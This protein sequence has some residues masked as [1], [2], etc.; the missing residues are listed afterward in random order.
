MKDRGLQKGKATRTK[1][2]VASPLNTTGIDGDIRV[3][4]TAKGPKLKVKSNGK[5]WTQELIDETQS[6]TSGFVPKV[7]TEKGITRGSAGN[8]YIYPPSFVTNNTIIA[9]NFGISLG[10]YERTYFSLGPT[11]AGSGYQMFV[12]YNKQQKYIRFE[13]GSGVS[14]QGKDFTLAVFYEDRKS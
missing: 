12:H 11:G 7:W 6:Q 8:Q 14:V 4:E 10:A 1:A 2:G 9:I 13:I 5:W 3:V